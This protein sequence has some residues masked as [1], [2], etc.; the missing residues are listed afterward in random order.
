MVLSV[1]RSLLMQLAAGQKYS[2]RCVIGLASC[3][4]ESDATSERR[5]LPQSRHLDSCLP[6]HAIEMVLQ[7]QSEP[8]HVN[9]VLP[10]CPAIHN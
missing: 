4:D 3:L 10:E 1:S 8:L 6:K 2:S 5:C 9:H 7:R